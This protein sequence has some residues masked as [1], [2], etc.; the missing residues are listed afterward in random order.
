MDNN[1]V[2]IP[3]REEIPQEMTWDLTAIYKTNK[4]WETDFAKIDGLLEDVLQYEGKIKDG[5][6]TLKALIE[7]NDNLERLAEKLYVYSHL[8]ADQDT[9]NSP[10]QALNSRISTKFAEISGQLAWIEPEILD[11]PVEKFEEYKNSDVLAFY[12]RTLLETER[13]R[14][15]TLSH[16]EERLL[17]MASDALGASSNTFGMLNNADLKFPV[18]TLPNGE[19]KELTHGNYI[20]FLENNDRSVRSLAFKAMYKTFK[21]FRNTFAS[22]LD[23]NLKTHIFSAEI[24]K[25]P[26]ALEASLHSDNVPKEVYENLIATVKKHL[27]TLFRYF[28]LRAKVMNLDNLAMYDLFNPLVA[29]SKMTVEWDDACSWVKEAFKPL[30]IDYCSKLENA[31]S[32]RWIDVLENRGK[33]SGAYSSGCFDTYPYLLLNYT[34]TLNDVYTLAHEL[35][36]SMHSFYSHEAQEY[37]YAD[38]KIFVA[39]VASTTNEMLLHHYLMNKAKAADDKKLQ[40]YLL[41]HLA[42][43]IRGTIYRQTMFAEFEKIIHENMENA[44]PTTADYL[45]ETYFNLNKEYHAENVD[46]DEEIGMEWA[47][48]PHFYY[49]FYV[50]KYATGMSAAIQLS[51][52]ILSGNDEKLEKY[53]NFLKA[54]S[55]KDVLDIM[56]DA[57]VD[58]TTPAPVEAAL[59]VFAEVVDELEKLLL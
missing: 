21:S 45:T 40:A 58:L 52:N 5:P 15:H 35:G 18:L 16:A 59:N 55:S 53:L 14:A 6:E 1:T 34:K 42:D 51:E 38:Y 36:H 44:V 3:T 43:G 17:G 22:T 41:T 46:L 57:G 20:E 11:L 49:N 30:G 37:H 39:E 47:R 32:Q 29:E 31:F 7:A 54:G 48:I 13:D 8:L 9:A 56:K 27:P 23:G 2:S 50:Y 19:K 25:H 26:S 28:K 10:N 12:K 24:R 33:R 4:D